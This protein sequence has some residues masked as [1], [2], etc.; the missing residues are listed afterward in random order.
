MLLTLPGHNWKWG[1]RWALY[2]FVL[3][4]AEFVYTGQVLFSSHKL[5]ILGLNKV[6]RVHVQPPNL[7]TYLIPLKGW[8][9][10]VLWLFPC[11]WGENNK[12]TVYRQFPCQKFLSINTIKIRLTC[13]IALSLQNELFNSQLIL[14]NWLISPPPPL[15][16]VLLLY[17]VLLRSCCQ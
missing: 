15:S 13:L 14:S 17:L 1:N 11:Q 10:S 8:R 3:Y 9:K 6:I 7:S 5:L 16:Q 12:K 4:H 2:C